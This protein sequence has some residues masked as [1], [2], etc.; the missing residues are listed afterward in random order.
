MRLGK[1]WMDIGFRYIN[2][3]S[4]GK[5]KAYNSVTSLND[6]EGLFVSHYSVAK[7]ECVNHVAKMLGKT[8]NP[9]EH[10]YSRVINYIK[11]Q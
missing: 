2:F 10:L 11:E 9:K 3:I 6:G 8:Q 7:H 4:D 5:R 1:M